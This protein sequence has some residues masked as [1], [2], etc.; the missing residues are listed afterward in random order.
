MSDNLRTLKKIT[1][2]FFTTFLFHDSIQE[3]VDEIAKCKKDKE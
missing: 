1:R 3:D 2:S